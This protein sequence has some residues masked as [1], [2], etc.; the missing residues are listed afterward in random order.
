MT[1]GSDPSATMY[2]TE[3]SYNVRNVIPIDEIIEYE[4]MDNIEGI[5]DIQKYNKGGY[6]PVHIDDIIDGRFEVVHKLGSG[7][8]G[9]VWFCRDLILGKWRAIKIM[10]ADHS[11]GSREESINK[12]LRSQC[13]LAELE[14]NYITMPLEEFWLEGPNGRHRCLVMPVLGWTV[15][16]WRLKQK[17][18]KE[19]TSIDSRNICRQITKAMHF[20]HSYGICHGDFRPSNILMKVEGIDE[21]SKDQVL[22]LMGEPDCVE[23]ETVSGQT[24]TPRAP[25]YC[26]I[27]AREFWSE[28]LF[29]KTIAI[30]DFG[31]SFFADSP[32]K[33]TGIPSL[34]AAPEVLFQGPII[35]GFPSDI[36]SLACT[37]FEVR[38][39]APLFM[40]DLG[41]GIDIP[42]NEIGLFLG[43][44]PQPY[45]RV[46][47]DMIR[48]LLPRASH[49]YGDESGT[50]SAESNAVPPKE[51]F[52]PEKPKPDRYSNRRKELIQE[53]GY[54][55]VFEAI[56]G[57]EQTVYSRRRSGNTRE[58]IK[59]R[60]PREDVLGLADL[61]RKM[62]KYDPAERISI[63]TVFAHPWIRVIN[64]NSAL[65]TLSCVVV[66]VIASLIHFHQ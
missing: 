13:T 1:T 19:Q 45:Q 46:F 33:S 66:G 48:K 27:P 3:S 60:Y 29:T 8:F 30:I 42:V 49:S 7:G 16:N 56:L 26:V 50:Q 53:T 38:T 18:Y 14:E 61:L 65:V 5:E 39:Y 64:K 25:E 10:A 28:T 36:W 11:S 51:D 32:P 44:L 9:I 43:P 52:E 22:E 23:I 54:S 2:S 40:S 41:G 58:C 15:S 20:L 34:Y 37:L 6:Y 24:P 12:Y 62:L 57:R 63:N 17:D 35:P 21:L 55:D 47:S 59:Y 4:S 31:E